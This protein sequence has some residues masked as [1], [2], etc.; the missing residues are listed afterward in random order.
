MSQKNLESIYDI[1]I[2]NIDAEII[3]ERL[4]RYGFEE[5]FME[6]RNIARISINL[7]LGVSTSPESFDMKRVFNS[8]ITLETL[9]N[10]FESLTGINY[11]HGDNNN[12]TSKG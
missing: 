8:Y 1:N 6:M 5:P 9:F 4:L 11:E 12:Y 7:G 3:K 10:F 2:N